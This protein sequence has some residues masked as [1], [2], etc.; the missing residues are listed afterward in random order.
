MKV[1]KPVQFTINASLLRRIDA[2]PEV[3]K[4]GRS[5]FLRRAAEVALRHRRE[6]EY[7]AAYDRGYGGRPVSPEEF[8]VDPERLA[9]PDR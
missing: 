5:A 4:H 9:W 8:H 6:R 3:R 1:M 2:L 7:D